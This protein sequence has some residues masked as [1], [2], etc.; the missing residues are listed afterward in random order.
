MI[1]ISPWYKAKQKAKRL[2]SLFELVY[3]RMATSAPLAVP[4][5]RLDE[6]MLDSGLDSHRVIDC[7]ATLADR[8]RK[9]RQLKLRFHPDRAASNGLRDDEAHAAFIWLGQIFDGDENAPQL[10]F[11][12]PGYIRPAQRLGPRCTPVKRIPRTVNAERPPTRAADAPP[13]MAAPA[14]RTAWL[15]RARLVQISLIACAVLVGLLAL[16]AAAR[17]TFAVGRGAADLVA[18]AL[19]AGGALAAAAAEMADVVGGSAAEL[20]GHLYGRTTGT[21]AAALAALAAARERALA[22]AKADCHDSL[23][24][25]ALALMA[26]SAGATSGGALQLIFAAVATLAAARPQSARTLVTALAASPAADARELAAAAAAALAEV[27]AALPS[28]GAPRPLLLDRVATIVVASF[29]R[30]P[31]S[32]PSVPPALGARALEAVRIASATRL[33]LPPVG[34]GVALGACVV[35]VVVAVGVRHAL[36]ARRLAAARSAWT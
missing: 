3:A 12:R 21:D 36:R 25:G 9:L 29:E 33:S 20:W 14:R 34:A 35:G 7:L 13:P 32:Q 8:Q 10:P 26:I 2:P 1:L 15:P 11:D 5:A 27:T 18:R 23:A 31:P 28:I 19:G 24:L 4:Q 17:A 6:I 30:T 16:P 22:A